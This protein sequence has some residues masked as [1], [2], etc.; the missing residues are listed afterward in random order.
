[1]TPGKCLLGFSISNAAA[2]AQ[3]PGGS[4][5]ACFIMA[6]DFFPSFTIYE[7]A[8]VKEL[9][10]G[11]NLV[12]DPIDFATTKNE[13]GPKVSGFI[14]YFCTVPKKWPSKEG[15]IMG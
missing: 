7:L 9:R 11:G 1:M 10:A 2:R 12:Y 3:S 6:S 13:K 4:F 8:K 14:Y 5:F 15:N